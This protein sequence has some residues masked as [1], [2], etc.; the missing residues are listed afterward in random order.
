MAYKQKIYSGNGSTTGYKYAVGQN[1]ATNAK[2]GS[3]QY[4]P[5]GQGRNASTGNKPVTQT[6]TYTGGSSSS[7]KKPS[8][9]SATGYTGT[10]DY[11]GLLASYMNTLNASAKA[12]YDRSMGI[13]NDYYNEAAGR[14]RDNYNESVGIL[15][16]NNARNKT[17]AKADAE[18]AMR[19][20]YINNMLSRQSLQQAMTAQ[21]LNGGA[22]ET[23]RASMENNYGNA[24]NN[25]DTT[26]Q[27]NLAELMTQYQNNLAGLRQQ[28]NNGLSD[29][30]A[31]R[32]EYSMQI[33]DRLQ[34]MLDSYA[35]KIS[36]YVGNMSDAHSQ[37]E[38][39]IGSI[40]G[41][42][43]VA[44]AAKNAFGSYNGGSGAAGMG[45][46]INSYL[47]NLQNIANAS[48]YVDMMAAEAQNDY[49]PTS[50]E[51]AGMYANSNYA[52]LKEA[53]EALGA[54]PT[55]ATNTTLANNG[56][57][58]SLAQILRALAAQYGA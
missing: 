7:V 55:G 9:P 27:K 5:G 30:D 31:R 22:T 38:S 20:A 58:S 51:Q 19:Q 45:S 21:G 42:V 57:V 8:S 2:G 10:W 43:E 37:G 18:G 46:A 34:S 24:R 36:S 53:Q 35:D 15:D 12:A 41:A 23:T 49:N 54:N 48:Q 28:L 40:L 4:S 16:R 26:L 50:M 3:G 56:G 13:V 32:M 6:P 39:D 29:L 25:I 17:S 52:R 33:N 14:L 11:S 1:N 47:A 44:K